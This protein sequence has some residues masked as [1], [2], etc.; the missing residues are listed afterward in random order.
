MNDAEKQRFLASLERDLPK[1][2]AKLEKL[3][4]EM[5]GLEGDDKIAKGREAVQVKLE[6]DGM[7]STIKQ[8]KKELR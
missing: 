3:K 4:K 8:L 2:R 5:R 6:I 1:M 7:A